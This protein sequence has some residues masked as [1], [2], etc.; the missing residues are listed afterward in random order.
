MEGHWCVALDRRYIEEHDIVGRYLSGDLTLRETRDFESYCL[1]HPDVL[2]QLPIPHRLKAGLARRAPTAEAPAADTGSLTARKPIAPAVAESQTPPSPDDIPH[3]AGGGRSRR[4]LIPGLAALS[5]GLVFLLLLSYLHSRALDQ[6]FAA[7]REETRILNPRA[8]SSLRALRI[9]PARQ[10]SPSTPNAVIGWP[11]PP[12][13]IE[14]RIDVTQ[15]RYNTFSL[16]I[17]KIGEARIVE[18]RRIAPDS[19]RELRLDL[20]SSAFGPGEYEL[21]LEGYTWRG[22]L[23]EAG[24]IRLSL[25][26]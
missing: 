6:E 2:E 9:I 5:A 1:A 16:T 18:I 3:H 8:P 4:W 26:R 13:L 15:I 23:E 21:K 14:L 7:F 11:D 20:N 17:D 12:E 10:G 22:Q 25:T 19:N 24:W